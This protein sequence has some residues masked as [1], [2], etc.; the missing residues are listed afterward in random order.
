M[1]LKFYSNFD[2]KVKKSTIK[3]SLKKSALHD[4]PFLEVLIIKPTE[5][6]NLHQY[7]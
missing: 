4:L 3:K 6:L 1:E 2:A 5:V 7:F